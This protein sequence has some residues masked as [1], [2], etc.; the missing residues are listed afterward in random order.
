MYI[1]RRSTRRRQR[2]RRANAAPPRDRRSVRDDTAAESRGSCNGAVRA[3]TNDSTRRAAATAPPPQPCRQLNGHPIVLFRTLAAAHC[4]ALHT[5]RPLFLSY[6]RVLPRI[7]L[8]YF[9][10][11]CARQSLAWRRKARNFNYC[12]SLCNISIFHYVVAPS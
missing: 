1:I 6:F 10:F 8:S 3:A 12:S 4:C 9:I 5:A 7:A 2:M 11:F